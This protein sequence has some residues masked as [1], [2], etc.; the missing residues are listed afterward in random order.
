MLCI[1]KLRLW[2]FRTERVTIF[3]EPF[4]K[5]FSLAVVFAV[6]LSVPL[7]VDASPVEWVMALDVVI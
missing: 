3:W 7:M 6:P 2:Y 5:R 4:G 1:V